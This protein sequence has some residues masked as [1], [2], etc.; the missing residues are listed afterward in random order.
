GRAPRAPTEV[1]RHRD[2]GGPVP[3]RVL[4]G[5]DGAPRLRPLALHRADAAQPDQELHRL[6]HV[7]PPGAPPLPEGADLPP[8][9]AVEAAGRRGAGALLEA[10]VLAMVLV[11]GAT[12]SL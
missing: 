11:A 12:G 4:R 9:K 1:P 2:A 10:G 7:L 3:H 8:G 6:R 5:L